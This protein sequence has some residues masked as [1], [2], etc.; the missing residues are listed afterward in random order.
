MRR[1]GTLQWIYYYRYD[2]IATKVSV[3][4]VVAYFEI[5]V[6]KAGRKI[7]PHV[8]LRGC[9][10]L[11]AQAVSEND[12]R[13]R[14]N[15]IIDHIHIS[16]PVL[17]VIFVKPVNAFHCDNCVTFFAFLIGLHTAHLILSIASICYSTADAAAEAHHFRLSSILLERWLCANVRRLHQLNHNEEFNLISQWVTRFHADGAYKQRFGR[18]TLS[19]QP[20]CSH[21]LLFSH[22]IALLESAERRR[23]GGHAVRGKAASAHTTGC[24]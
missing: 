14:Y 9:Y 22:R 16:E 3:T 15:K 10:F 4:T 2:L 1:H 5:A 12:T 11:Y 23:S 13:A 7:L 17:L 24:R 19:L 8:T 21:S 6:W 20:S 18:M